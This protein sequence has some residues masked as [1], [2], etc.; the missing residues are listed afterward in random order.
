MSGI[1]KEGRANHALQQIRLER[2]GC[3]RRVL[4]AGSLSLGSL[5][6]ACALR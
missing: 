5:R 3:N 1:E 4:F 6:D 2:R